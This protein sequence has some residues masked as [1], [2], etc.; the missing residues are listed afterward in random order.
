MFMM[1][2]ALV[3]ICFAVSSISFAQQAAPTKAPAKTTV[4]GKAPAKAAQPAVP[5][6]PGAVQGA[7]ATQAIESQPKTMESQPGIVPNS[8]PG[9]TYEQNPAE[10]QQMAC[11]LN[12]LIKAAEAKASASESAET[13]ASR[14]A[15]IVSRKRELKGAL[16]VYKKI[17][18]Q[19]LNLDTA[20]Q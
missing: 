20:C 1:K 11:E 8:N 3:G 18:G 6:A 17:T 9:D 14:E 2:K 16:S 12:A 10:S 4:K 19:A 5:A 7:P 15:L 13:R